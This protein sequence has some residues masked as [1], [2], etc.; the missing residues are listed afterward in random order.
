MELVSNKKWIFKQRE[1]SVK[2]YISRV[3]YK[4]SA[5]YLADVFGS[6]SVYIFV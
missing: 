4:N 5:K 1:S 2:T 6:F 3:V